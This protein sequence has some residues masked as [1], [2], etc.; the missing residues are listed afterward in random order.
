MPPPNVSNAA[1]NAIVAAVTCASP[2]ANYL[3]Q[4]AAEIFGE[5]HVQQSL[6]PRLDPIQESA[7]PN[8]RWRSDNL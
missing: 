2:L 8:S 4:Y 3:A 5:W 6:A 7:L 1:I